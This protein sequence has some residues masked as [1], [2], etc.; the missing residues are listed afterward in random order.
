MAEAAV[1]EKDTE[2]RAGMYR[3]LQRLHQK[4]SPFIPMS[5]RII[6]DAMPENV[7]G[8]VAGGAITNTF[9]WTVTK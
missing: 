3:E 8:L 6:Q 7:K 5:Q 2:K 9:Y 4:E 1:L